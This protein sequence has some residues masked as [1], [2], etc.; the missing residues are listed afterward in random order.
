MICSHK[1]VVFVKNKLITLDTVVPILVEMK[2]KYNIPS[3]VVVFDNLAHEAIS[4]NIVLRDAINYVGSE[5]FITR[6]KKNKILRRL[7]VSTSFLRLFISFLCGAKILHFGLF[8]SWP[9]K[10]IAY[11]F[12][13]QVYQLQSMSFDFDY[14]ISMSRNGK[15]FVYPIGENIVI[16][17]KKSG[18][19]YYR[20]V[21]N[22]KKVFYFGETRTRPHWVKYIRNK[23]DY[24]F[25][26]YCKNIDFSRGAIVFILGAISSLE[27][28]HILF[29]STIKVLLEKSGGIPILLKP[30]A[31]TEIEVVQNA[32]HGHEN[33]HITYLHPSILSTRAIVFIGNSF[34]N[35][36]ADAHSFGVSTIEYSNESASSNF[37]ESLIS[38]SRSIEPKYV[39]YFIN[40]DEEKF[41]NILENVLLNTYSASTFNGLPG[42]NDELL[43]SLSSK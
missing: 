37:D 5:L 21:L 35:T 38:S 3:E 36:M 14:S 31:F 42:A 22:K 1:I 40:N 39:D 30:H 33:I 27:Y 19:D 34:S 9:F 32:I 13:R 2:D 24:Y 4:N 6:G 25:N 7:Y 28:K 12:K 20:S 8:S 10:H 23:S 26:L 41:S 11:L 43:T 15:P 17:G 16:F 29:K 18:M